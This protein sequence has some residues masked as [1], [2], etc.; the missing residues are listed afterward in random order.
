[1]IEMD[2]RVRYEIALGA[3]RGLEYLHHACERPVIHRDVKSSNILLEE[4]MKPKI[5]DFGLAKIVPNL[6]QLLN[7]EASGLVEPFTLMK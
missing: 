2:W 6:K 1:M 7:E 4:D 3:T 5:V